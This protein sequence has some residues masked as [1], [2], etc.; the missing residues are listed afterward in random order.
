[1][2]RWIAGVA[3]VAL[4][5]GIAGPVAAKAGSSAKAPKSAVVKPVAPKPAAPKSTPKA[6]A[7]V[8]GNPGPKS[9]SYPGPDQPEI[10]VDPS[11]PRRN[12]SFKVEVEHFC[13]RGSV[14][15]TFSGPGS[16]PGPLT[17]STNRYG[18]GYVRV[19]RGISTSGTYTVTA[20]CDSAPAFTATTTF[21]VR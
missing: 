21:R 18:K 8:A 4:V 10:K 13:T 7:P 1:M 11:R 17:L 14:T 5:V 15:V 16:V 3:A 6:P 20:T 2:K 12:R 19:S 9:G